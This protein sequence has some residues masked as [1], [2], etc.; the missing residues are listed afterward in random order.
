MGY[1]SRIIFRSFFYFSQT[2]HR[3]KRSKLNVFFERT[4]CLADCNVPHCNSL[5]SLRH[6]NFISKIHA[7]TFPFPTSGFGERE[8]EQF[9]VRLVW[10]LVRKQQKNQCECSTSTY[11]GTYETKHLL[12]ECVLCTGCKNISR[13]HITCLSLHMCNG[14]CILC[15][16]ENVFKAST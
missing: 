5:P 4:F 13:W 16:N 15:Q 11:L 12:L 14:I 8:R 7:R 10:Y 9:S 1:S 6:L 2:M 3:T